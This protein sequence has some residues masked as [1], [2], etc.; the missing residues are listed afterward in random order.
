MRGR[1]LAGKFES[2]G[3]SFPARTWIFVL[4]FFYITEV[5]FCEL[6]IQKLI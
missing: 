2:D 4:L 3:R 6:F 5:V 1:V